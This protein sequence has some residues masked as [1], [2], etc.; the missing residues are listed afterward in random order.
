MDSLAGA[1]GAQGPQGIQGDTGPQGVQGDP[2]ADGSDGAQGI[3]GVPG[4]DGA[5]GATGAQ[6]DQGIQ[7]IPGNDGADGATGAQ[8]DQGIQGPPG[9]D[10]ADGAG[11][12]AV[13]ACFRVSGSSNILNTSD[14]QMVFD[15]TDVSNANYSLTTGTVTVTA[16]GT[17]FISYSIPMNEDG[18]G[19]ATRSRG[20]SWVTDDG[21]PIPQSY[22]QG[23]VRE[24]S[25][26]GGTS[27]GFVAVLGAGSEIE[28]YARTQ[29]NTD[30]SSETG[31]AQLSIFRARV[32][33]V[34]KTL[35]PCVKVG[36]DW[37]ANDRTVATR[38]K[39]F[40]ALRQGTPHV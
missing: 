36:A 7:G 21:T 26:G 11:V 38:V 4:N 37:R 24:A 14:S 40:R 5:D 28:L 17:Y 10:G 33:T 27:S 19:G 9:N 15:T 25:G 20:Y 39:C 22:S 34:K 1:D 3:Q 13:P 8:G 6:G 30:V 23:Y 12:D 2:G 31:Q 32:M 18:T 16:A 35:G 29:N